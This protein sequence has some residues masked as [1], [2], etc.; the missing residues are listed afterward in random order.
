MTAVT[1][2]VTMIIS[3]TI[4]RTITGDRCRSFL[5]SEWIT[6]AAL[7]AARAFAVAQPHYALPAVTVK[8]VTVTVCPDAIDVLLS[9]RSVVTLP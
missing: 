7:A 6:A 3:K 4:K 5:A 9:T 1:G 2:T 8:L